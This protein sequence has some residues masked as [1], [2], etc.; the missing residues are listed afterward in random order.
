[1]KLL[2]VSV[3]SEKTKGGIATWT[4]HFL[5]GCEAAGLGCTLVNTEVSGKRAETGR[6]S[7]VGELE[8]TVR[9]FKDL[10]SSLRNSSA[11]VAHLNTSCGPF[12]L[13]RDLMIA[14]QIK[15]KKIPLVTHYHCDI[16][17]W[18]HN[19]LSHWC[20]GK[21]ARL[22]DSN[23]V[24]CESSRLYLEKEYS[25]HSIK[26]P[27]FI[28][29]SLLTQ[30][31]KTI[32]PQLKQIVFVGRVEV[33]KG[34]AEML[35]LAR[36]CPDM[37][38]ELIGDVNAAVS[39]WEW[40]KNVT[41]PGSMSHGQVIDRLDVADLFLFPSHSEGF[42][43][44]LMEAMARGLPTIATDVGANAD[45]LTDNSGIIVKMGD[46]DGMYAAI[47]KLEDPS[48]RET[49]SH[50]SVEKVRKTYTID[51]VFKSIMQIYRD[52]V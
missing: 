50:N 1:M 36:R 32:S 49:F 29:K 12:G 28:D 33:E 31:K 44:A 34:A 17:F 23:L 3:K 2:L 40:P 6:R 13:F 38:F 11:D 8:R 51:A 27:N 42:S 45:M 39:Q 15:K 16:P 52:A 21:L 43:V 14:Y 22:S 20:L 19:K 48:V 10:G 4:S 47:K 24:L 46:T 9:I 7:F 30:E 18:I 5:P 35:E 37:Q 25:V 41:M 26:V